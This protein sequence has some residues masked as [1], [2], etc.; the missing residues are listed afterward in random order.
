MTASAALPSVYVA[1][2]QRD[3][4]LDQLRHRRDH[5]PELVARRAVEGRLAEH[6]AARARHEAAR[7]ALNQRLAAGDGERA[8]ID[9]K[10][11]AL[12]TRQRNLVVVREAE[13]VQHEIALLRT[14][15]S[16][17]DDGDLALLDELEQIDTAD[18]AVAAAEAADTEALGA[19][20]AEH[21]AADASLMDEHTAVSAE[22]DAIVAT[23]SDAQLTAYDRQRSSHGGVAIATLHGSV[24]QPCNVTQPRTEVERIR[25][26]PGTEMG[27]CEQC[28]RWLVAAPSI[29]TADRPG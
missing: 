12:A 13:A 24:C 9:A 19:A 2:A 14:R 18:D 20:T 10:L 3:T 28:G 5:L 26:L 21:A 7:A 29:S 16:E 1:L 22:R 4:H 8:E 15:L 23:L 27:E 6:R 11:A 25:A 17:L